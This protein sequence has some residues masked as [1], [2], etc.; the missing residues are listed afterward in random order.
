MIENKGL[1]PTPLWELVR[2][3]KSWCYGL[4]WGVKSL[5]VSLASSWEEKWAGYGE[6][7]VNWNS[8]PWILQEDTGIFVYLSPLPTL[9]AWRHAGSVSTLCQ[10]VGHAPDSG[11]G[12]AESRSPAGARG[13]EGLGSSPH[14]YGSWRISDH[15]HTS[16]HSPWCPGPNLKV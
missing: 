16:H 2:S 14:N 7:R 8:R 9:V 4:V 13:A 5:Q 6:N 3:H 1:D 15:T 10:G 11:L 12:E